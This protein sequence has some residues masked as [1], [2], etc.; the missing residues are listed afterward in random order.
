MRVFFCEAESDGCSVMHL[1]AVCY[2]EGGTDFSDYFRHYKK[3]I[4]S[5]YGSPKTIVV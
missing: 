2:Y 1:D 4:F 5:V 3:Y